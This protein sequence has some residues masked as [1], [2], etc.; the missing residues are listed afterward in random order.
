M[1]TK[2][3]RSMDLTIKN[4]DDSIRVELH[5]DP[6]VKINTYGDIHVWLSLRAKENI[7]LLDDNG[8]I[9]RSNVLFNYPESLKATSV[10]YFNRFY[11]VYFTYG[12]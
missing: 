2:L 12:E 8:V 10:D 9:I 4:M 5:L 11:M 1:T 3:T 7:R 6:N